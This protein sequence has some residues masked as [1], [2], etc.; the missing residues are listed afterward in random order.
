MS[1][2]ITEFASNRIASLMKKSSMEDGYLRI[3]LRSGGCSG[4]SYNFE[5]VGSPDENDKVFDLMGVNVCVDK[6]SYLFLN[7][8]EI[9]YEET[10]LKSGI[11]IS[12]PNAKTKCGCGESISF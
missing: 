10:I 11:I 12:N 5:F 8:M 9:D 7:G 2:R 3:S 6:K 1:I 4:F